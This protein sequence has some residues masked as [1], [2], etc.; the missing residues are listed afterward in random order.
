MSWRLLKRA[1]AGARCLICREPVDE[2]IPCWRGKDSHGTTVYIESSCT[3]DHGCAILTKRFG[4]EAKSKD[5]RGAC[6][7]LGFL[8]GKDLE[9]LRRSG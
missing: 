1:P 7:L 9:A 3:G 4:E 8:G 6:S 2:A 5:V